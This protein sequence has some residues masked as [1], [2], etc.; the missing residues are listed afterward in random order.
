MKLGDFEP[1]VDAQR[2]V[3][4][5]QRL[6]EQEELGL[7]NDGTADGDALALAAGELGRSPV[8]IGVQREHGRSRADAPAD[9]VR[10]GAGLLQAQPHVV[11]DGEV[12]IERVGLKDH[13]DA[14]LGRRHRRHFPSF[15]PDAA[16]GGV[17]ESG[18]DPQQSR[19]AAAGGPDENDEL[20]ILHLEVDSPYDLDRSEPL[21]DALELQHAP[22]RRP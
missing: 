12:R 16:A 7:A 13:G 14:A 19:L 20:A 6:V 8:E 11:P 2:G 3:E 1:R 22:T 15:Y 18:D 17:F 5:G 9:L 10:G 4:I 21:G